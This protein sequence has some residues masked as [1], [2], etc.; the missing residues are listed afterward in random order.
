M[1][2]KS[3]LSIVF[4]FVFSVVG[5]CSNAVAVTAGDMRIATIAALIYVLPMFIDSVEELSTMYI[6]TLMQRRILVLSLTVGIMYLLLI[7]GYWAFRIGN[8][9]LAVDTVVKDAFRIILI[10]LPAIYTVGKLYDLRVA[11]RQNKNV[12]NAYCKES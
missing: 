3:L 6:V 8:V 2:Q 9:V 5:L 1:K 12:A 7:L 10:T 4:A 11:L